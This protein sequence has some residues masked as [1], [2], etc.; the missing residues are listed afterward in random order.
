MMSQRM[1]RMEDK[2]YQAMAVMDTST[3]KML[4]YRQLW[5]N[6]K[7][8]FHW[9]KLAASGFRRLANVVGN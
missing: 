8:K 9:D 2:V 1:A 5:R 4:N 3:G 6:P 7:Y